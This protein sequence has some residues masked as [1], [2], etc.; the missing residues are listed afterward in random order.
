MEALA[1][2]GMSFGASGFT[3]AIIAMN[4]AN[5]VKKEL[6]ELKKKLARIIPFMYIKGR[7]AHVSRAVVVNS[8]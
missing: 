5:C 6:R 8:S 1:I 7:N 3:F 4:Q 2:M